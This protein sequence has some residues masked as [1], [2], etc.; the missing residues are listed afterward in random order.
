MLILDTRL[1]VNLFTPQGNKCYGKIY[2][3]LQRQTGKLQINLKVSVLASLSK[4]S[5][6]VLPKTPELMQYLHTA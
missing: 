4:P 3:C 2:V 1:L 5:V 6:S